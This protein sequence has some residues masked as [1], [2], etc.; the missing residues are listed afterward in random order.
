MRER[1]A[2][3]D[4]EDVEETDVEEHVEADVEERGV[5]YGRLADLKADTTVRKHGT[6]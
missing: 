1:G 2:A 6:N 5:Q 3:S 4:V